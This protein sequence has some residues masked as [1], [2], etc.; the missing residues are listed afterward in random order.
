[1][2]GHATAARA[3]PGSRPLTAAEYA[4]TVTG[5]VNLT[6]SFD[7]GIDV[8]ESVMGST[9]F[10]VKPVCT[11][12]HQWRSEVD[13]RLQ[14]RRKNLKLGEQTSWG[15]E[16]GVLSPRGAPPQKTTFIFLFENGVLW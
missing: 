4:G 5:F 9:Y 10:W 16:K 3:E 15:C 7:S 11:V 6:K 14:G 2:N 13:R 8:V 1:M 12:A